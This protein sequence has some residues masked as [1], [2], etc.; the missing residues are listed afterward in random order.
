MPD[1]NYF[2][3][4][5]ILAAYIIRAV[6]LWSFANL[7]FLKSHLTWHYLTRK[8]ALALGTLNI[9]YPAMRVL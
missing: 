2:T 4:V 1:T 6:N 9:S 7:V 8:L 3:K 5:Y